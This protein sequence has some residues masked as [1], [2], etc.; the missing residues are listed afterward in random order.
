MKFKKTLIIFLFTFTKIVF[1]FSLSASLINA[2]PNNPE[3]IGKF[4]YE[5]IQAANLSCEVKKAKF[6]IIIANKRLEEAVRMTKEDNCSYVEE[7]IK[8]YKDCLTLGIKIYGKL[9]E[10]ENKEEILHLLEKCLF[11][12]VVDLTYLL[13]NS[14][15]EYKNTIQKSLDFI[16]DKRKEVEKI[17]EE[18]K[19]QKTE[20]K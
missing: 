10:R 2:T 14:S 18:L 4:T 16:L 12:N 1:P 20:D 6:F 17:I 5:I 19:K 15:K 9:R 7:L 11:K 3:Y 8:A 13:R